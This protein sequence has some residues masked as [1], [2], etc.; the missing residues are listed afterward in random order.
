MPEH[1]S[2]RTR[3]YQLA[4][5]LLILSDGLLADSDFDLSEHM[6]I[7]QVCGWNPKTEEDVKAMD[8]TTMGKKLTREM[9]EKIET[10]HEEMRNGN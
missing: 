3:T 9:M 7:I 2:E 4:S 6:M 8:L 10:R 1:W 5:S